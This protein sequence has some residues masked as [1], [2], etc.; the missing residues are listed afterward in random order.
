MT[1]HFLSKEAQGRFSQARFDSIR[2][3]ARVAAEEQCAFVVVAGDIFESNQVDRQTVHRALEA[4]REFRVPVLLLPGNHDPLDAATVYRSTSFLGKRPDNV[5]VIEDSQ[6]IRVVDGVEVVGAPWTSKRPL[7]DLLARVLRGLPPAGG[8]LRVAVAHG[9]VDTLSPDGSSPSRIIVAAAEEALSQRQVHYVALGDRHSVTEVGSS[10]RIWYSGTP[11]PTD[12]DEVKP[13]FVLVVDADRESCSVTEVATGTWRF[14]EWPE[15]SATS[16]EDIES[17]RQRIEALPDK[18]RTVL[19]ARLKGALSLRLDATLRAVLDHGRDLLAALEVREA[20]YVVVPEGQ[21][22]EALAFSGFVRA[23]A[24]ELMTKAKAEGSSA[25]EA[26]D[27][28][29]LLIRL[30][31]GE[32]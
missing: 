28:L 14:T 20:D 27:A 30:T 23:T 3:I 12:Y 26:R 13:G 10:R 16:P 32:S 25:G 9:A 17:V 4:L 21:D 18:E 19:K 6:P 11:E 8:T 5:H 22:F 15:I 1:R 7:D 2:S 24:E 31:V 29:A